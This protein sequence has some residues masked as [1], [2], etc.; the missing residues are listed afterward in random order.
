MSNSSEKCETDGQKVGEKDKQT[1]NSDFLRPY[2]GQGSNIL[3]TT[4]KKK[5][6][7]TCNILHVIIAAI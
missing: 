2:I 4:L 3:N 1:D 6:R 7:V 5:K